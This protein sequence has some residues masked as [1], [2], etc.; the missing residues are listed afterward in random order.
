MLQKMPSCLKT[1]LTY[2]VPHPMAA[3]GSLQLPIYASPEHLRESEYTP[4]GGGTAD[5]DLTDGSPDGEVIYGALF[6]SC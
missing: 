3:F 4:A 6:E 2:P 5:T 1:C